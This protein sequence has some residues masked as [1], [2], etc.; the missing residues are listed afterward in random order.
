MRREKWASSV[1]EKSASKE[2]SL[3]IARSSSRTRWWAL[4]WTER[5]ML[6]MRLR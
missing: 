3:Y 5:K 4:T 2:A 1:S 6:C